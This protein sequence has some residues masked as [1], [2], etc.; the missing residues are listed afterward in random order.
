MLSKDFRVADKTAMLTDVC[1]LLARWVLAVMPG[2]LV[3]SIMLSMDYNAKRHRAKHN[4]GSC[5]A[6]AWS[7]FNGGELLD[8]HKDGRKMDSS[9]LAVSDAVSYDVKRHY[10][11]IN[12]RNTHEVTARQYPRSYSAA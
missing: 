2:L 8:W 7:D 1:L 6:R 9:K 4:E 10:V 3:T 11:L 12:G 5:V